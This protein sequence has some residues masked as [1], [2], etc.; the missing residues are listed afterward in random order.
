MKS[1]VDKI[2]SYGVPW[3]Y[4]EPIPGADPHQEED[5]EVR[6]ESFSPARLF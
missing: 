2:N 5:Y 6:S 1:N 4:W 3:M